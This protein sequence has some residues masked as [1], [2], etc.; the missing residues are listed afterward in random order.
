MNGVLFNLKTYKDESDTNLDVFVAKV[1]DGKPRAPG[2]PPFLMTSDQ[3]Q[4][5]N[6]RFLLLDE[7]FEKEKILDF[8]DLTI[9]ANDF[10]ILGPEVRLKCT[11]NEFFRQ[12]GLT[13]RAVCNQLYLY[14]I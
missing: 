3:I 7:N 13:G 11:Y 9:T 14:Q 1:D 4:I 5:T 10:E 8:S 12:K 6:G 2:T